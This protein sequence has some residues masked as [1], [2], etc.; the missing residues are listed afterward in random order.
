VTDWAVFPHPSDD[1]RYPGAAL[2][3]HWE[4]LHE[5]DREPF[6]DP[7]WV[8]ALDRDYAI[9]DGADP[10]QVAAELADAWR[11]YHAGDFEQAWQR[12][13][14]L[15]VIG[16]YVANKANGIHAVYLE[17]DE[18]RRLQ[19]FEA[20]ADAAAAAA[21]AMPGHANSHYFRAF[22]LGRYSQGISVAKALK[23]G[24]GGKIRKSLEEALALEPEHADAHT[25]MGLYH[26]EVIDKVGSMLGA[27]TYGANREEAEAHFQA[28]LAAAP[29][30][31]ITRI[32]A[33]NGLLM[34]HG[35]DAYDQASD[36]YVEASEME[37]ADAMER[38]D[39]E[40]ALS[41]LE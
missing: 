24:M 28:A 2:K 20:I 21:E 11:D 31:A 1:F 39:V 15:G 14:A 19:R 41:E 30:S 22:A 17:T 5:G 25:A 29:H 23:Q 18:K 12:G 35:D 4:R 26:A 9:L 32:E 7:S 40:L 36:L 16:T 8:K 33:A 6:P 34:L 37:P 38:L 3:K 13:T 27:L 10:G